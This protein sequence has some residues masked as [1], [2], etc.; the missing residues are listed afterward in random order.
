MKNAYALGVSLRSA[1]RKAMR[2]A[3]VEHYNDQAALF[4]HS[5]KK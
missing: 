4:G 1:W 2:S 5:V 3:A